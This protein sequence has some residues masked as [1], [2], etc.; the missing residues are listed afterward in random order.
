[1]K[2]LYLITAR[3]GSK[4]LPRKNVKF[5]G[6]KPL[7]VYTIEFALKNIK[8]GD[9]LCISSNDDEVLLIAK[10]MGVEIAFKRPEEYATDTA[11]SYD[12]IIHALRFYESA[13]HSFDAILMLQ[14]TSPF[15]EDDDFNNMISAYSDD[16]DM[17]VSV[18][19]S[20]ENPYFNLFEENSCGYLKKSK[21]GT[22]TR[23]QDCPPV[24]AYNGSMYLMNTSSV[25]KSPLTGFSKVRKVIMP[26][27]RSIDIDTLADW[28]L[29]EFYLKKQ[30]NVKES[31]NRS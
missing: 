6:G 1:M 20:K 2:I 14:P 29:A 9:V 26:D 13:G 10:R 21:D 4:G 30:N 17:V 8:A 7:I 16:L 23:R 5:L 31:L 27:E 12:V 11:S 25:R 22:F 3:A 19:Q 15:R 18:K 24:F 28:E